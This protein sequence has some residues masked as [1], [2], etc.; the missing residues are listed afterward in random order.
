MMN[1][2]RFKEILIKL[3]E[4]NMTCFEWEEVKR[5]IDGFFEREKDKTVLDMNKIEIVEINEKE[6]YCR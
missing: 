5:K 6:Y 1:G 3:N 4:C 2:K